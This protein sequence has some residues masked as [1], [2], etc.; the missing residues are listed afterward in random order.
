VGLVLACYVC[1]AFMMAGL[2]ELFPLWASLDPEDGGLGFAAT[3]I[4]TVQMI[5]GVALVL[6]TTMVLPRVG[7]SCGVTLMF[8]GF[9]VLYMLVCAATPFIHGLLPYPPLMWTA[10]ILLYIVRSIAGPSSFTAIGCLVNN[11]ASENIGAVN[12]VATSCTALA[13]ALAPVLTGSLLGWTL[14]NRLP[15]PLDY[16]LP[17]LFLAGIVLAS[18]L[19]TGFF[20][21]GMDIRIEDREATE[22]ADNG[23]E[24]EAAGAKGNDGVYSRLRDGSVGNTPCDPDL[25]SSAWHG[26]SSTGVVPAAVGVAKGDTGA[27]N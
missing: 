19:M 27:S 20:P 21:K 18:S 16:H 15:A 23:Q 17:W 11:A 5:M 4:G 6:Y 24:M 7:K 2:Q 26:N 12:G 13:R 10:L 8:Q 9:S 3:E 14:E 1:L 22:Q 25:E